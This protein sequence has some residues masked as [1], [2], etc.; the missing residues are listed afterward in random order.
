MEVCLGVTTCDKCGKTMKKD[1]SIIVIAEGLI[2]RSED[3]LDFE[4]ASV[5][6]ACH[7]DCWDGVEEN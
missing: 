7:V 3:D 4:C 6:Y 1:Q 2:T 5:R